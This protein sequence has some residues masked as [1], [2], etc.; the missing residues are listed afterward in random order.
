[1]REHQQRQEAVQRYIQGEKVAS[2]ARSMG[3]SRKWVHHWINRYK[4]SQNAPFWYRDE[5]KAPKKTNKTISSETEHQIL[6]IRHELA[7]EKMAQTGLFPFNMNL[8]E[9]GLI[10]HR[11]SGPSTGLFQNMDLTS[12]NPITKHQKNI[13]NYLW[14]L[15]KW[16]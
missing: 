10:R 14:I 15:I 6:L 11:L 9:E 12:K 13:R 2:I 7:K 5:S 1:M 8:K 16:I 3:K 4:A